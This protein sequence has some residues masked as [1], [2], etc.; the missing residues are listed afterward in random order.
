MALNSMDGVLVLFS[1]CESLLCKDFY[2]LNNVELVSGSKLKRVKLISK[3]MECLGECMHTT[4]CESF[5]VF[6]DV[7]Q[8]L[9]CDLYGVSNE[10]LLNKQKAIYFKGKESIA[11]DPKI[12]PSTLSMSQ[13]TSAPTEDLPTSD[14]FL[15]TKQIEKSS[16][17][18]KA[19]AIPSVIEAAS[20]SA[21]YK[22]TVLA[23]VLFP[24]TQA[25]NQS[26]IQPKFSG[27]S[28]YNQYSTTTLRTRLITTSQG[29]ENAF[30]VQTALTMQSNFIAILGTTMYSIKLPEKNYFT[31]TQKTTKIPSKDTVPNTKYSTLTVTLKVTNS[32]QIT[33]A[34]KTRK[35]YTKQTTVNTKPS[36]RAMPNSMYYSATVTVTQKTGKTSSQTTILEKSTPKFTREAM[37]KT[38]VK[39]SPERT[40]LIFNQYSTKKTT[41]NI[42]VPHANSIKQIGEK[43]KGKTKQTEE[44]RNMQMTLIL[45]FA[46][47]K[48]CKS[49]QYLNAVPESS[50]LSLTQI[51]KKHLATQVTSTGFILHSITILSTTTF[52]IIEIKE[53]SYIK[54]TNSVP[55]FAALETTKSTKYSSL[56]H[57]VVS[58]G[59]NKVPKRSFTIEKDLV[60]ITHCVSSSLKWKIKLSSEDCQ[61]IEFSDNRI[62]ALPNGKCFGMSVI[63]SFIKLKVFPLCSIFAYHSTTEQFQSTDNTDKCIQF[64]L[65]LAPIITGCNVAGGYQVKRL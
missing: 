19:L 43:G 8:S 13:S 2:M 21:Q 1:I 24:R 65:I 14:S 31:I 38:L 57:R 54:K 35:P 23:S 36:I 52:S 48:S 63:G 27:T 62:L 41:Q 45:N 46:I 15:T 44:V 39:Q 4:G 47:T 10:I 50:S 51:A 58:I 37:E 33:H 25:P 32:F 9:V 61:I 17:V 59:T 34:F 26:S 60:A 55:Q 7:V 16:I 28:L 42:F 12:L 49:E 11:A 22:T 53:K 64:S 30:I 56:V 40:T 18:K 6:Y 3:P 5:N 29:K 20:L